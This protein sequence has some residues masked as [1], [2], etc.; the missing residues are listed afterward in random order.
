MKH[1]GKI[2][3][4]AVIAAALTGC[5]SSPSATTTGQG[6]A[7]GFIPGTLRVADIEEPDT[8]NP[9]ISTVITSIDLSYLWGQYF[10]NV[11]DKD[12]FVPEVALEVPTFAN[13]GI[14]ADGLTI[15]YHLR[16][17]IKWQDGVPLTAKDVVFTWH[18][19]MNPKN[20]V[21]VRTGYDQIASISTPDDYTVVLHMKSRFAP[22][23]AYFMGLQGGG[24]ILPAHVLAQQPDFNRVPFNNM[25]IGSGPF[26]VVEW[27]HGDHITLAANPAYWRGAPKLHQIIYKWIASNTTIMT[28]LQ[29]G[30]A[31]A[32]F[33]A[34]PGLYPQLA[35][36]PGHTSILTPYSIFGH[37]D[38]YTR[39]PILQDVNVRRA[40]GLAIDR[41]KIIH[42][43]THDVYLPSNSDQPAFSWAFDPSLPPT[44]QD[45]PAARAL[46]D[47]SGWKPGPDGIRVKNGQRLDLQLSYV[48]GQIVAPAIGALMERELKDVGISLSQK[49][50]PSSTYFAAAENHGILNSHNFQIAYFAWINGVDPDDSSLYMCKYIP[51]A[52]QN[53]L[54]WCDPKVD[55]LENDAL[56]TFDIEKRKQD[57]FEIQRE[58][59]DQAPTIVLFSERRVDT[60]T[61][62]FHGYIPSPAQ[63]A[64]WNSWQWS[65][66]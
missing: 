29:T 22:I 18:A 17:G 35:K 6:S 3:L 21:Q 59:V 52:G 63:S 19:I 8:L 47:A 60:F 38:F 57:Y 53:N 39:D 54:W 30:E 13:R 9:Y 4:A 27:V 58:L 34:D 24:P 42:D 61:T 40:V 37:L 11:D 28:E 62:H 15:T 20:I 16:H 32:W 48:G 51:P 14:S 2:L 12:H 5:S 44:T 10:Y 49:Q 41:A 64:D 50:Y 46:L 33:R 66:E 31:D 7:A 56:T 25:P 45:Q 1:I 65:M 43:A 23:I 26:K 55:A 36:M